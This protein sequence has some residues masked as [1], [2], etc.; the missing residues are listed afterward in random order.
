M[1]LEPRG[2]RPAQTPAL[3]R[4]AEGVVARQVRR[5]SGTYMDCDS[6]IALQVAHEV[7]SSLDC[8]EPLGKG[9]TSI[10]CRRTAERAK[11]QGRVTGREA[12]DVASEPPGLSRRCGWFTGSAG[13]SPAARSYF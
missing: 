10:K 13:T 8:A 1:R 4:L 7:S 5:T 12:R 6:G 2:K 3:R 11:G 9:S